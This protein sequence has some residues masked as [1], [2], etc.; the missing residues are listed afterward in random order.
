M[1][2]SD[3]NE[4]LV[5]QGET[6]T[7]IEHQKA[8]YLLLC[9]FDRVCQEL[10]IKY[11]LF[12]GTL[13]GAVRHRGFIPWDD[14]LDIIMM[15]SD[16]QRFLERAGAVINTER[17]YLQREYSEHWPFFFSK[18]RLNKTTCIEKYHPKDNDSHQGVYID[19]FPCDNAYNGDIAKKVQFLASKVVIAK[20]LYKRGYETES[21]IKKAFMAFCCVLPNA[22]FHRIVK[23][24]RK[25]GKY[26]HSFLGGSSKYSKSV[27]PSDCFKKIEKMCFEGGSYPVPAG[28]DELLNILY[29]D[30]M[31]LPS[32]EE[33]K[34]KQHV[35]LVDLTK[36][37]QHY[38]NYRDGITFADK[39]RSIR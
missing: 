13:L 31:V 1:N 14:D 22:P 9:E 37:Y 5:Q 3:V 17:F 19:I 30:Y 32:E 26:L 6:A 21:A 36:S 2:D 18:F 12:A 10:D 38:R 20:G 25:T 4:I 28:Y 16:Y 34:C 35:F 8:L 15:H 7:L 11:Y 29:G 24:P 27:Y 23:G 39:T 33:R